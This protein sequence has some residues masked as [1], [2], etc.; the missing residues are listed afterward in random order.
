MRTG[1]TDPIQSEVQ[2][3]RVSA[4]PAASLAGPRINGLAS[5][6]TLDLNAFTGDGQASLAKWA[7]SNIGQRAWI[8]CSSAG[9]ASLEVLG[10]GGAVI[11]STEAANGLVNKAV[12]R[13][14]LTALANNAQITVAAAVNFS[15]DTNRANA[16]GFSPVQYTLHKPLLNDISDFTN[17]NF[18]GWTSSYQLFI[19]LS[20]TDYYLH[21][22]NGLLLVKHFYGVVP[23]TFEVSVTYRNAGTLAS[24]SNYI[25][26]VPGANYPFASVESSQWATKTT[27]HINVTASDMRVQVVL[28]N[29]DTKITYIRVRRVY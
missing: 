29:N 2:T 5:G 24:P 13:S 28:P 1:V 11:T 7:L 4:I 12:L 6:S 10:A 18:N 27:T 14:W 22:P 8:T 26:L 23:G 19:G 21:G 3:V 17:Y 20:G 25:W 16:V 9:A 15:G